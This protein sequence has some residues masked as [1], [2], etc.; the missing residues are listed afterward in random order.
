MKLTQSR[1]KRPFIVNVVMFAIINEIVGAIFHGNPH[2]PYRSEAI[3]YMIVVGIWSS[4]LFVVSIIY[5]G[6]PTTEDGNDAFV[7]AIV[8]IFILITIPISTV[9]SI[10]EFG[11]SSDLY[12]ILKTFGFSILPGGFIV[13]IPIFYYGMLIFLLGTDP[14]EDTPELDSDSEA[15]PLISQ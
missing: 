12:T 9:F 15:T 6:R 14:S 10:Y 2:F 7:P 13:G 1:F 4:L 5:Y 8:L 11:Y 3:T